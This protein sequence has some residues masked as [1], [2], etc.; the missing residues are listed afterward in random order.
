M[1]DSFNELV[2]FPVWPLPQTVLEVRCD[3]L[4]GVLPY[5]NTVVRN[6]IIRPVRSEG[7][8]LRANDP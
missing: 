3:C 6:T 2:Y 5:K 4:M 8:P 1:G 7:F